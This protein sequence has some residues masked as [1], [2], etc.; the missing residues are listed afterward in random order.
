MK[1]IYGAGAAATLAGGFLVGAAPVA[2][3][4]DVEARGTCSASS[5]WEASGELERGRWEL[6]FEVKTAKAGQRWKLTVKQNGSRVASQTTRAVVEDDDGSLRA[7]ARWELRRPDHP[8][9][10]E[11]FDLKAKNL[12]TGEVCKA[13]IRE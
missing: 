4:A 2:M 12:A 13:T 7:E 6:E 11:A 5:R 3:A 10:R 8:N 9:E 1:R